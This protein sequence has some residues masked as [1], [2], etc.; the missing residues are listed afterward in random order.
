MAWFKNLRLTTQLILSFV[1]VGLVSVVTGG[2][3]LYGSSAISKLMSDTYD[4][5]VM[6]IKD[7]AMANVQLATMQQTLNFYAMATD[8]KSRAEEASGHASAKKA[9]L[10]IEAKEKATSMGTEE[11]GLWQH[12]DEILPK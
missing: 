1:I 12:F 3:G 2:F 5:D 6:G 9:L 8:P 7:T 10:E 4:S 11:K